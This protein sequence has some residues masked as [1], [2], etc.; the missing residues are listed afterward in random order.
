MARRPRVG[1]VAIAGAR[2]PDSNTASQ[3]HELSA[4]LRTRA[5]R[6]D[7]ADA[8]GREALEQYAAASKMVPKT[9][10]ACELDMAR[11]LFAGEAAGDAALA[12]RELYLAARKHHA[13]LGPGASTCLDNL[14]RLLSAADA[15]RPTGEA[16]RNLEKDA[17]RGMYVASPSPPKVSAWR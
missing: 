6:L 16:L 3:A 5:Y 10:R 9:P 2:D 7:H 14:D 12:F 4:R 13:A 11:A 1:A 8:D 15:Y 17:D